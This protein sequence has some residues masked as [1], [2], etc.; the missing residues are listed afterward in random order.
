MRALNAEIAQKETEKKGP[1]LNTT[2]WSV[3]VYTMPAGQPTLKVKLQKTAAALQ[4]AWE[5]VPLPAGAHPATGTDKHLVVWQPSTD[6]LWEFWKLEEG[7]EGWHASWGGAIESVS[8]NSGAYGPEAWSGAK[9]GWGASATSLSIAGGLVTLE[10]LETGVIN[11]A[12]A[13]AI[14]KPRGG[15]IFATP[16]H[17]TD[18]WSTEPLAIPEGAHLR[19]D[20]KL[21]LTSL[22]LPKLTRMLAEAAQKYGIFVRDA[23]SNVVFYGQDPTPTGTNPYPGTSGYYEGKSVTQIMAAFPWSHL[24]LLQMEL[25]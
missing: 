7:T 14:P 3:P 8:S 6:K 13:M 20:P 22:N 17:R 5:A 4:A 15:G 24:Q 2:A 12:L 21:N 1:M 10:D 9:T 19:L 25:L 16:A 11:H 18:G 23:A